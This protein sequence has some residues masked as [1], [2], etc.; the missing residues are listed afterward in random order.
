MK[1][2]VVNVNAE[3]KESSLYVS[4]SSLL[5]V[6]T[7][8]VREGQLRSKLFAIDFVTVE[9]LIQISNYFLFIIYFFA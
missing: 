2:I 5:I 6:S 9:V 1:K 7:A 4:H 3:K 8:V